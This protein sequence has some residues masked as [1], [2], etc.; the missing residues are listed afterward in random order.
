MERPSSEFG[1]K[2]H[3]VG[4]SVAKCPTNPGYGSHELSHVTKRLHSVA[5]HYFDLTIAGTRRRVSR[6]R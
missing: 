3:I 2:E 4:T 5:A 6:D 1:Y